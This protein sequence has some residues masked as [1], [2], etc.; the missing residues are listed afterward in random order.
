MYSVN[1]PVPGR[2]RRVASDLEPQLVAFAHRPQD[3]TLLLKRLA[4]STPSERH[5]VQRQVR[6][7]LHGLGPFSVRITGVDYFKDP[8]SGT[9]PVVY[10]RVESPGLVGAHDRLVDE[11]GAFDGLGGEDYVP[12]ITI[13]RDGPIEAAEAIADVDVESVEWTA[14]RLEFY[15]AHREEPTGEIRLPA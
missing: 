8:T 15:D 14:E 12:H 13:A 3:H 7:A 10:L 2:V 4:A 9:S 1:V 6:D 11:L 5:R